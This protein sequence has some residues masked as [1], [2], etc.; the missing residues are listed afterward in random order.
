MK[1]KDKLN[2]VGNIQIIDIVKEKISG[3]QDI[4]KWKW[5]TGYTEDGW[6]ESDWFW[7]CSEVLI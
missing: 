6:L 3:Y 1:R 2:D 4:W 7:L 5:L